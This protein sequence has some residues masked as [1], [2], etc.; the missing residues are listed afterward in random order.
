M[1]VIHRSQTLGVWEYGLDSGAVCRPEDLVG[2][3]TDDWQAHANTVGS[4]DRRRERLG[5]PG[6][7][8]DE[9]D[10]VQ[11]AVVQVRVWAILQRVELGVGDFGVITLNA[12]VLRA[13]AR[14]TVGDAAARAS[15][16]RSSGSESNSY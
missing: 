11:D 12:H 16:S 5:L 9:F 2:R 4:R 14:R 1:R 3:M 8:E 13:R 6:K 10:G 15:N 7:P